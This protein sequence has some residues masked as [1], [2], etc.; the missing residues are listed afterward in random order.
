MLVTS[1]L[2]CTHVPL[3]LSARQSSHNRRAVLGLQR[4]ERNHKRNHNNIYGGRGSR[5]KKECFTTT[6]SLRVWNAGKQRLNSPSPGRQ[7]VPRLGLLT[8]FFAEPG[9]KQSD[10][11]V[12]C[13]YSEVMVEKSFCYLGSNVRDSLFIWLRDPW[14]AEK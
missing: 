13:G 10:F 3:P 5:N 4:R 14:S 8:L 9:D 11:L 7:L 6:R 12:L 1:L 2:S